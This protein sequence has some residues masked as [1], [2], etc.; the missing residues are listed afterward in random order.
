MS[1]IRGLDFTTKI[2][3]IILVFAVS[4]I[5]LYLALSQVLGGNENYSY[6]SGMM[7]DMMH[8]TTD[9]TVAI[10]L[11]I[12]IALIAAV[13][14]SLWL[15]PTRTVTQTAAPKPDS[16]EIIKR[17]LSDDEK[18]VLDEIS[19]AGEIT[20]DSLRFR[21]EW[22]KPKLSRILTNL[23]KLNLIQRERFGKT[24]KVFITKEASEP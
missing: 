4:Y 19:R 11:S 18:A 17:A 8:P 20:Q 3:V 12:T 14:F 13:L 23:D 1:N 6:G 5:A 2:I 15:K 24:Y 21:L 10:L 22:S 7:G 9:Y 16:L